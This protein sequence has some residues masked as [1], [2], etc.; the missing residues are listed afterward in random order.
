MV[1]AVKLWFRS[2]SREL[3][4]KGQREQKYQFQATLFRNCIFVRWKFN[5]D[6]KTTTKCSK[7]LLSPSC[8]LFLHSPSLCSSSFRPHTSAWYRSGQ[9]FWSESRYLGQ[10]T[11]W[12]VAN[13]WINVKER[14]GGHSGHTVSLTSQI[15][16]S[17]NI[18]VSFF[19]SSDWSDQNCSTIQL[20]ELSHNGWWRS[21]A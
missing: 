5:R 3:S 15:S 13:G 1:R 12:Q 14:N 11:C 6:R 20:I 21:R 9:D 17:S 7:S 2:I 8:P 18:N 16:D 10:W 4:C 19:P